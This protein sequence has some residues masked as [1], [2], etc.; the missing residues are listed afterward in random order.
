MFTVRTLSSPISITTFELD[1]RTDTA[2]IDLSI[3]VYTLVNGY[4]DVYNVESSWTLVA[5]TMV[6]PVPGSATNSVLIP[7]QDFEKLF[8]S[9]NE[10]RSFNIRIPHRYIETT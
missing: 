9:A 5:K 10:L 2:D 4:T 1:I 8:M 6:V 3:E 7:V